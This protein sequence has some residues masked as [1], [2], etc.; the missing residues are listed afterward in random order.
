MR[1]LKNVF[2]VL[3]MLVV[4]CVVVVEFA[5][6]NVVA[7]VRAALVR[8]ADE[9]ARQSVVIRKFTSSS[10]FEAVYTVPAGKKFVL[11]H[12]NCTSLGP[13]L[14]AGVYLGN[15]THANIAHAVPIISNAAG[16]TI[17]DSSARFYYDPGTDV[18]LRIFTSDATTCTLTGYT[19]DLS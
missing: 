15:F 12:M 4:A 19:V 6:K 17:A 3:G 11:E 18:N 5:P 1:A 16:V 7:Q 9:P 10:I 8:D 13:N 14:F 2:T